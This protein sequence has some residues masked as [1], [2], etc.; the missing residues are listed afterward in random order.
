MAK[1]YCTEA[2]AEGGACMAKCVQRIVVPGRLVT[3][4]CAK[5]RVTKVAAKRQGWALF[6]LDNEAAAR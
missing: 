6:D 5:H 4:R 2:V 3:H 1:P